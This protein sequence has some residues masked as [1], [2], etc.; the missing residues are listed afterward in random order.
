MGGVFVKPTLGQKI[1]SAARKLNKVV[2]ASKTLSTVASLL[3]VAADLAP[4]VGS[5][6]DI[7]EGIRDGDMAQVAMGAGGLIADGLTLGTAS[8]FKGAIKNGVKAVIKGGSKKV[9][10]EGGEGLTKK[11]ARKIPCGCFIAGTLIFTDVGAKPIEQIKLGDIVWAYNDTTG[12]YGQKKVIHLFQFERD[13]VYHIAIG[14]ETI[15]ATADHPFYIGGRWLRVA[16]L[17]VGD[18]VKLFDGSNLVIEQIT[19]VPGRTTVY[20]FEVEDYH[21]YYVGDTKVLVHNSGPCPNE[22]RD[23]RKYGQAKDLKG[24]EGVYEHFYK[25]AD[26]NIKSYTGQTKDLGGSR[27]KTSLRERSDMATPE[28]Y[29]YSHSRLTTLEGSGF[30]S[31]N[32]LERATLKT[33][34]GTIK[35][36]GKTYNINNVA[37]N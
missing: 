3:R 15:K 11:I 29:N 25:D 34:G 2:K 20:N 23:L 28:G 10:K 22:I 14:K 12:Q 36:G 1:A 33:N 7:Y 37:G 18:S 13:S 4:V 32:D 17:K 19:V 16:E 5:A 9:V 24:K 30:G 26:G 31:L 21:T 35:Q 8:V 27:P 6:L